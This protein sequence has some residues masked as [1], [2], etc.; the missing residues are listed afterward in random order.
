MLKKNDVSGM[1]LLFGPGA[2]S[3][4]AAKK[5]PAHACRPGAQSERFVKRL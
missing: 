2:I 5:R 1:T 3:L 4:T